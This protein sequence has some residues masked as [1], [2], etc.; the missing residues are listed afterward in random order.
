MRSE[1]GPLALFAALL[2]ILGVATPPVAAQ[3]GGV[4]TLC[5]GGSVP[6]KPGDRPSPLDPA[7]CHALCSAR[8]GEEER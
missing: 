3:A 6:V 5:S 7:A 8:R 4:T 1:P 2:A